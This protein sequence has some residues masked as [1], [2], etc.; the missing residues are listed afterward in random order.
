VVNEEKLFCSF[1]SY[2]F[3]VSLTAISAFPL[4]LGREALSYIV[5]ENIRDDLAN[6]GSYLNAT[7][8]YELK[9]FLVVLHH[10]TCQFNTGHLELCNVLK[11][12]KTVDYRSVFNV[13]ELRMNIMSYL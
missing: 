8:L 1:I 13:E 3:T 10:K 6:S 4:I 2:A 5:N 11:V 7:R 9:S 12:E